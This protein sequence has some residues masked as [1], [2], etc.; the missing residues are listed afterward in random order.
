MP[1]QII[2]KWMR[3][4][5]INLFIVALLGVTMRYKIAYS[6][7]FIDQKK[8]L[9]AHSHFAFVGWITQAL[10]VLLVVYLVKQGGILFL[11]K[12]KWLLI[13]NLIS[14]YGMLFS[15]PFEGYGLYSII[16]STL[17][18]FVSYVF[19]IMFWRDLNRLPEKNIS[20]SWFKAAVLFNAISSIG[21]FTLAGMMA[22]KTVHQNWYLQALYFFLHFQYNGW[23]FFACMGLL[24]D[25]L[26]R[27]G[28]SP[29][30]LKTIFWIFAIT[31]VPAYIL[32]VLW[33]KI[34]VWV[35]VIV[36]IAAIAQVAGWL[37]MLRIFYKATD[38]IKSFSVTVKWLFMVSALAVSLKLLLQLGS[39]IPV[40]SHL[41]YG[42]RPIVIAYLHLVLLGVITLFIMG[43]IVADNYVVLNKKMYAGIF[44]FTAGIILN[45]MI[46]TIQGIA[47]LYYIAIPF[48]NEMLLAISIIMLLGI[49]LFNIS[50]RK[51]SR[52]LFHSSVH[53]IIR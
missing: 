29:K 9:N 25:K 48:I 37:L 11:K 32:S 7:P 13:A 14:A 1:E 22:T 27:F 30:S 34:P 45:E 4:A 23:F 17:A 16:F 10:M 3:I 49:F 36:V 46:L 38:F 12:Y 2:K 20:H 21:A 42:F 39:T 51:D 43:Y 5:F 18:I 53:P 47:D 26:C 28:I 31:C 40:L 8:F 33:V 50:Q 6:L 19:A 24:T 35:Y 15:F 52:E 44:I 41:A